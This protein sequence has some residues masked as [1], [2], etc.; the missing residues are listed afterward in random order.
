MTE[1]FEVHKFEDGQFYFELHL[2]N[3]QVI[4]SKAYKTK[5]STIKGIRSLQRNIFCAEIEDKIINK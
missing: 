1:N 2:P 4:Q 5:H 3:S